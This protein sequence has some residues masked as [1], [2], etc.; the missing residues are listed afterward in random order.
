MPNRSETRSTPT[1]FCPSQVQVSPRVCSLI[2]GGGLCLITRR[3]CVKI[4]AIFSIKG[5]FSWCSTKALVVLLDDF[6]IHCWLSDIIGFCRWEGPMAL[7]YNGHFRTILSTR[8]FSWKHNLLLVYLSSSNEINF[9]NVASSSI[10]T[11]YAK[12]VTSILFYLKY[13]IFITFLLLEFFKT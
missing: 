10:K 8:I 3:W 6:E 9:L 13:S 2:M 7:P 5:P 4:K 12:K 11:Y 1:L